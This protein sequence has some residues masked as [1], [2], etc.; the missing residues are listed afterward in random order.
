MPDNFFLLYL[1]S[2]PR[3][4]PVLSIFS[5]REL[6]LSRIDVSSLRLPI[7]ALFVCVFSLSYFSSCML[8]LLFFFVSFLVIPLFIFCA[9]FSFLFRL[10]FLRFPSLRSLPP[11]SHHLSLFSFS[12]LSSSSVLLFVSSSLARSFPSLFYKHVFFLL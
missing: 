5:S 9:Q 6:E 8:S 7:R 3:L 1:N 12:P 11:Y 2:F 10:F 4:S